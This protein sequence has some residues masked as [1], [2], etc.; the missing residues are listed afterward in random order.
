MIGTLEPRKNLPLA[1]D[2]ITILRKDGLDLRL[3]LAG[4]SSP[5]LDV[6]ELLEERGLG[7][8]DVVVT[9]YV[10][11]PH[12]AQLVAGARMLVFPSLY[13]GF[14]M[15]LVE[16]MEAGLPIVGARAG[17]TPETVGDAGL[18]VDPDDAEAFADAMS[19]LASDDELRAQLVAAGH[20]QAAKFTW[21]RAAQ[22]ALEI[23]TE[24]AG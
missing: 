10:D 2:A 21:D 24:L 20:R 11:D 23:Y 22:S 4:S 12:L 16:A 8:S 3:V 18:L 7:P 5:L 9:G 14:G 15:P 13:E 6:A 19:R 1:L 17:A